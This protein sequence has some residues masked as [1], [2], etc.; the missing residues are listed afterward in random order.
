MMRYGYSGMHYSGLM[1]I[2]SILCTLFFTILIVYLLVKIIRNGKLHGQ[3]FHGTNFGMANSTAKTLEILNI[4]YVNSEITDE[5]YNT[6]KEQILK[7]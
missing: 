1:I 3:Y 2:P 4:R 5:E 7:K 6:K